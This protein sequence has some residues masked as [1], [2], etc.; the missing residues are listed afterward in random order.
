MPFRRA[1]VADAARNARITH[2]ARARDG[3]HNKH[4]PPLAS[5]IRNS[6][7]CAE[8]ADSGPTPKPDSHFNMG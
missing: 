4:K 1:F 6:R 5:L 8:A 3:A 2:Q 7:K